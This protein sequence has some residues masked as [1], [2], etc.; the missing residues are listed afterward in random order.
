MSL[1]DG[2]LFAAVLALLLGFVAPQ[3]ST[4]VQMLLAATFILIADVRLL[5]ALM[6]LQFTPTDFKGG[7]A[8]S[9]ETQ[10]ERFEGIVIF[11]AGFPFTTN[12][13]LLLA[14]LLRVLF[15][16]LT[17][18]GI[19]RGTL[20]F[21]GVLTWLCTLGVAINNSFLG[22]AL[23]NPSWSA[24]TRIVLAYGAL[25][26]GAVMNSD[27]RLLLEVLRRRVAPF[28]MVVLGLVF[29]EAV[30]NRLT[31]MIIALSMTLAVDAWYGDAT[32]RRRQLHAGILMFLALTVGSGLRATPAMM[33]LARQRGGNYSATL[34]TM[35]VPLIT[36]AFLWLC[37]PTRSHSTARSRPR[38]AVA[39]ATASAYLAFCIF[40][41][42][43]AGLTAGVDVEARGRGE[44]MTLRERVV[45]KL[46]LERASIW[47]GSID[48]MSLPPYV[49][50]PAGR[51]GYL[52]TNA[53]RSGR[54]KAGS[55]NMVLEA[56]RSEGFLVGAVTLYVF[57]LAVV[58]AAVACLVQPDAVGRIFGPS[59]IAVII[60]T[61]VSGASVLEPTLGFFTLL[62]AGVCIGGNQAGR[63]FM[64]RRTMSP[65]NRGVAWVT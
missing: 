33:E 2:A 26:L 36:G 56:L 47:R 39:I 25:W 42:L 45:Y 5:P 11:V 16:V 63:G 65:Q 17:R 40:P 34:T 64:R 44:G 13:V 29:C 35:L 62:F 21:A 32:S 8:A 14:L 7:V 6:A 23:G 15:D 41:F 9:M 19:L 12:Y 52:I 18:P 22:R 30:V 55:H 10:Y 27:R 28:V 31:W 1:G 58:A 57:G 37:W 61:G 59:V 60:G 24:P 53:G 48:Q 20:G 38:A 4:I 50:V 43:V 3:A 49:L 54:F 46:L 51:E